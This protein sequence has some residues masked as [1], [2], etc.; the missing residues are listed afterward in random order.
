VKINLVPNGRKGVVLASLCGGSARD[1][2]ALQ[3]REWF[4]PAFASLRRG[5]QGHGHRITNGRPTLLAD[6]RGETEFRKSALP[7]RIW[8]RERKGSRS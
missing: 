2:S 3:K 8:E 4:S 1:A 7:N 5:N 6:R